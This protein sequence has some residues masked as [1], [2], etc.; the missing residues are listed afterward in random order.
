MSPQPNTACSVCG[1]AIYRRPCHL[2][3]TPVCSRACKGAQTRAQFKGKESPQWEPFCTAEEL[4]R[5]YVERNMTEAEIAASWGVTRKRVATAM[6]KYGIR[7][8]KQVPRDQTGERHPHWKGK[9]IGYKGAHE[10]VARVRG[11]PQRCEFCGTTDPGFRYDWANLTRQYHDP[12]DYIRLCRP[13]H[14]RFDAERR[15]VRVRDAAA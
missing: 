4:R 13:C 7:H 12:N 8:R 11:R 2:G 10:R 3:A 14:G 1:T 6:R 15:K 5:D 9:A